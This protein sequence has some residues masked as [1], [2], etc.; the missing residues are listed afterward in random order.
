MCNLYICVNRKAIGCLLVAAVS[1][2]GMGE[3]GETMELG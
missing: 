2:V 3:M 1:I